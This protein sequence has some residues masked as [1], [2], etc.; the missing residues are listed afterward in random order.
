MGSSAGNTL[1]KIG[2]LFG[3][4]L[5]AAGLVMGFKAAVGAAFEFDQQMDAVQQ[6][7]SADM[8]PMMEEFNAGVMDMSVKF[9]EG[10]AS[11]ASGLGDIIDAGIAP[12]QALSVLNDSAILAKGGLFETETAARN[13]TTVLKAFN[14]DASESGRVIDIF[15]NVADRGRGSM[16]GL[17]SGMA[18]LSKLASDNGVSMEELGAA[19]A[20]ATRNGVPME[21]AI[22]GLKMVIMEMTKE[23]DKAAT[24]SGKLGLTLGQGKL[25]AGEFAQAIEILS[26]ATEADQTACINNS[27]AKTLLNSLLKD[28]AGFSRDYTTEIGKAGTAEERWG[29]IAEEAGTKWE[30]AKAAG[31]GV[32]VTIGD[33]L[34][35]LL[36]K[37]GILDNVTEGIVSLTREMKGSGSSFS[38]ITKEIKSTSDAYTTQRDNINA[39]AAEYESLSTKLSELPA[40]SKEYLDTQTKL[41]EVT[42]KIANILPDAVD[43][44][45]DYGNAISINIGYVETFN[46]QQ[47]VA[48]ERTMELKRAQLDLKASMDKDAYEQAKAD[49]SEY[50]QMILEAREDLRQIQ[51]GERTGVDFEGPGGE[52]LV[53]TIESLETKV[54]AARVTVQSYQNTLDELDE[55]NKT[56]ADTTTFW[57][58]ATG[59]LPGI[60]DKAAGSIKK[61]GTST[62]DLNDEIDEQIEGVSE[63]QKEWESFYKDQADLSGK[64]TNEILADIDRRIA[65]ME[66]EGRMGSDEYKALCNTRVSYLRDS[67]IEQREAEEEA[68]QRITDIWDGVNEDVKNSMSTALGDMFSGDSNFEDA[69][70]SMGDKIKDSFAQGFASALVEKSGFDLAF[71]GN[72]LDL[73][74]SASSIF[75]GGGAGGGGMLDGLSKGFSAITDAL[76]ITSAAAA[77]TAGEMAGI[78]EAVPP[79]VEGLQFPGAANGLSTVTV[80]ADGTTTALNGTAAAASSAGISIAGYAAIA[81][82]GLNGVVQGTEDIHEAWGSGDKSLAEKFGRTAIGVTKIISPATALTG[83]MAGLFG[84]SN[85]TADKISDVTAAM[86]L[87]AAVAGPFGAALGGLWASGNIGG[88]HVSFEEDMSENFENAQKTGQGIEDVFRSTYLRMTNY[89]NDYWGTQENLMAEDYVTRLAYYNKFAA[90]KQANG[91]SLFSEEQLSKFRDALQIST[92]QAEREA[93]A[94]RTAYDNSF[95]SIKD[96]MWETF[97]GSAWQFDIIGDWEVQWKAA[98][99][100]AKAS[101]G[102][103]WSIFIEKMKSVPGMTDE[104]MAK[105]SQMI[106]NLSEEVD[107]TIDTKG[108]ADSFR[109]L[110][111]QIGVSLGKAGL[112]TEEYASRVENI[113]SKFLAGWDI[114]LG[115]NLKSIPGMTGDM[116]S[117][118]AEELRA[119]KESGVTEFDLG[120]DFETRLKEVASNSGLWPGIESGGEGKDGKGGKGKTKFGGM[121]VPGVEEL[122]NALRE[123]VIPGLTAFVSELV[124]SGQGMANLNETQASSILNLIGAEDTL[125]NRQTLMGQTAEGTSNA[126]NTLLAASYSGAEGQ[127]MFGDG[128]G[129][130]TDQIGTFAWGNWM[131]PVNWQEYI[132]EV[133]LSNFVAGV[134]LTNFVT[135]GS[136]A[137]GTLRGEGSAAPTVGNINISLRI[138]QVSTES[139]F[140]EFEK[141]VSK[142]LTRS[143][144][145]ALAEVA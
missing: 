16:E 33:G 112:S 22:M 5:G 46:E 127:Q 65:E 110:V 24:A 56:L 71:K 78:G 113:A 9:G 109:G 72:M 145:N 38:D 104:I 82:I 34:T 3:V 52:Q 144:K 74:K 95:N 4:S 84:A 58:Q 138:G 13:V 106:G 108:A 64:T 49:L 97:S 118:L 93:M 114:D 29:R 45:D 10:T 111:D 87:G 116:V 99:D 137:R 90:L 55:A 122:G 68:A 21:Q 50:S 86:V 89:A 142:S 79:V 102:D 76:G 73:G 66:K 129:S 8:L 134:D 80:A 69:L 128:F 96:K 42:N 14:L 23:D 43:G 2:S 37:S 94:I 17:S 77:Q 130:L 107:L 100:E 83:T 70:S 139:D 67:L 25:G 136:G 143:I 75:G 131:L 51:S 123:Q 61:V 57:G 62:A 135:R 117:K 105:L 85:E 28:A 15:A 132:K 125:A 140:S 47:K 36:D 31:T 59:L 30:K 121:L 7:L 120:P 12:S 98:M 54:K 133:N 91:E 32:L 26:R 41:E 39:L 18:S 115:E 101:G 48:F 1:K 124:N 81:A 88:Q 20:T 126:L 53:K 63:W 44:W 6:R 119:L 60:M 19:L 40:G 11:L 92:N 103:A 27:K 35:I 141:R